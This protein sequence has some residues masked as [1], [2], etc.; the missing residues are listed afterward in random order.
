VYWKLDNDVTSARFLSE[1]ERAQA[2]ER[3]RAN[4]TGIGSREFEWDQALE[5]A[6][7]P[8]TYLWIAMSLLLNVGASVST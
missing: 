8:K 4:Q 6:I 3:L 2:V 5:V 1:H 7:E